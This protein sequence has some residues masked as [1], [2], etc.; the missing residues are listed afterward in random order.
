[1]RPFKSKAFIGV[2]LTAALFFTSTLAAQTKSTSGN[3]TFTVTAVGKKDADV[4][5]ISK[6][7]V[8]L[9]QSKER[10]QIGDWKKGDALFLAILI[11]DSIE[12]SAGGQWEY[13]KEFIMAQPPS[14][15]ILVG[16]ITDNGTR[17]VQDFT[18]NHELAAKALR[19]PIGI[20]ALGSSPYL[21]AIDLLKRWP[22][23]GPRRSLLMI[24]SG[25]DYFRGG[26]FGAFYPDL[27]S[28]ISRAERQNTNVWSIYYPSAS[29]RGRAFWLQNYA[30]NNM[31][32]LAEDTG[33]EAYFLGAGTPVSIKP[34]LDEISVHLNNQYLLSFAAT[35]G[36]KGKYQSMKVKTALKEVEFLTPAAV[37]IPPVGQ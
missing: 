7:D 5:N 37:Y 17:V 27:D 36:S 19:L 29:H 35:P 4:S 15:S 21:G 31:D 13:L 24:T 12:T 32:K 11:D 14:T 22:A 16:Y 25:I 6:D 8:Q 28:L 1:M 18:S 9:F 30:Q 26:G 3:V 10:K 20:G 33:A 34:Y 2:L 23:T